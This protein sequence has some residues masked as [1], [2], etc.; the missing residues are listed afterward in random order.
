V[1]AELKIFAA[2]LVVKPA[3]RF[4]RAIWCAKVPSIKRTAPGP[5]PKSRV[6]LSAALITSLLF[7]SERYELEFIRINLPSSPA[8]L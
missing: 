8:S 3:I 5:T 6:A 7:E 1:Y 4:S 2:G